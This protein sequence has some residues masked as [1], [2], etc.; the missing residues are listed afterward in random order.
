MIR[1]R[2]SKNLISRAWSGVNRVARFARDQRWLGSEKLPTRTVGIGNLQAGGAGKTPL[3]IRLARDAIASG[4]HVAILMRGYR[5]A[6]ERTGGILAPGDSA[7][8]PELCGDEPALIHDQV[9]EVWIGVGADRLGQFEKLQSQ[10]V[11]KTGRQFDLVILDDAFQHWKIECDQMVLAITDSEFGERIFRDDFSAVRPSD[12]IV[13]TKG[14]QF[15]EALR[16]HPQQIRAQFRVPAGDPGKS[17]RFVAAL[18]DPE[19]ARTSFVK[20]GYRIQGMTV[21][22]DHHS[23]SSSEVE[24]I[25]EEA[26]S[27][28]ETILLSGKDWVKWRA[29]GVSALS[30]QVVEPVIEIQAGLPLWE[31]IIHEG[32]AENR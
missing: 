10:A 28:G 8:S 32:F 19:R 6:W 31:R 15:P 23:F 25:I 20:A 1:L 21:F 5:S 2:T 29:L 24:K 11:L 27:L 12:L 7:P 13:L 17:Y 4:L 16:S 18:G 22:P 3:T 26:H 9:P 14:D 30:V